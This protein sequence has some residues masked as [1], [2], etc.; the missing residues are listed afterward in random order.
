MSPTR[1]LL[2][3]AAY[4]QIRRA[5][6]REKHDVYGEDYYRLSIIKEAE[7]LLLCLDTSRPVTNVYVCVYTQVPL[8]T[9]PVSMPVL[10][11]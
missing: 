1:V 5:R 11:N 6:I 4:W 2:V 7:A 10:Y 8:R 3:D 9:S